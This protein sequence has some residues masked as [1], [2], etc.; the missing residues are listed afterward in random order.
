MRSLGVAL[1]LYLAFSSPSLLADQLA[2]K[3]GDRLTG[4]ILKSDAM[5]LVI[6]TIVGG[7]VSVSW[8]EIQELRSDLPL[9]VELADGKILVGKVT[10]HEERLEVATNTGAVEAPK[11]SIVALRS[12]A[13]QSAYE[14]S[15]RGSLLYGWDGGVDVGFELTRGNSDTRDFRLAFRA[16]RKKARDQLTLYAQ[17]IYSLDD[18][19][20]A[21]PHITANENSGGVRFAHDLTERFFL[22]SNTDLMSDGLQDLNLRFVLGGGLGYHT[23]KR[24]RITLDLL[25]GM[26]FTHEDYVEIQRNLAAGQVG[27][28]FKLKLGK[29]TSMI[30]NVAFFP[31]LTASAGNYRVNFNFGTITKIVKWLG[32]QNNFSDTYVT[33]PPAGKKQNELV[34]T[35]GLR[36]AFLH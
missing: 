23:I 21:R 6:K 27:E 26:N 11:E 33:N 35:S 13:E 3:N 17:S 9:H 36:V 34:F 4:V 25:G 31:N 16:A 5:T 7:E 28:E 22:F 24:E 1:S 12:D 18:L 10:T 8:P 2:F 15:R 19:P 20:N 29:N 32:W 30:Q 14:R